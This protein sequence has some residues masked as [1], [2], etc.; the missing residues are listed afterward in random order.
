[1]P[2]LRDGVPKTPLQRACLAVKMCRARRNFRLRINDDM[3]VVDGDS[4]CGLTVYSEITHNNSGIIAIVPLSSVVYA[5]EKYPAWNDAN[6]AW[7]LIQYKG[8]K[9]WVNA[10]MLSEIPFNISDKELY[11]LPSVENLKIISI[12]AESAE[13]S[14]S[15]VPEASRYI[16]QYLTPDTNVWTED[17]EY[18]EGLSYITHKIEEQE[19]VCFRIRACK[20]E[21]ISA[22]KTIFFEN[23]LFMIEGKQ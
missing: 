2:L 20:K 23:N 9:G 15:K 12:D 8:T 7:T 10:D 18:S 4:E 16:V 22:W 21:E 11:K 5:Y 14:W 3:L 19:Y 1:M 6:E 13:I 17:D